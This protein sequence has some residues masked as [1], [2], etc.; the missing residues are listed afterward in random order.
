MIC[1][2]VAKLSLLHLVVPRA[3]TVEAPV[4]FLHREFTLKV[5]RR[6]PLFKSHANLLPPEMWPSAAR[7]QPTGSQLYCSGGLHCGVCGRYPTHTFRLQTH[8]LMVSSEK[9]QYHPPSHIGVLCLI[10]ILL[11]TSFLPPSL[12][13]QFHDS[14]ISHHSSSQMLYQII[15]LHITMSVSVLRIHGP[16]PSPFSLHFHGFP[17]DLP[18]G[19]PLLDIGLISEILPDVTTRP[20]AQPY[21]PARL[22]MYWFIMYG[23]Y[24]VYYT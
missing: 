14:T 17:P 9:Y 16:S 6:I 1:A 21:A 2:G 4:T 22:P 8:L 7:T 5:K 12:L 13:L 3:C 24:K 10:L 20:L 19:L 11:Y 18:H 23:M 15:P